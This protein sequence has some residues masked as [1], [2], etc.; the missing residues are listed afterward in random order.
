M[1]TVVYGDFEWDDEKANAN[2]V[3]H[4]VSFE[5]AASAVID[6][7]ALFLIDDSV[8]G[9]QRFRVIGMSLLPRLLLVV[10]VDRGERDRIISARRATHV[11]EELYAE[12]S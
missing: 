7:N 11:E 1:T 8:R 6:E 10:A 4:A 12:D 5:E 3:K 9:E 2:R